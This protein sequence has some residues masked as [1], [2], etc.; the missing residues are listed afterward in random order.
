MADYQQKPIDHEDNL[1]KWYKSQGQNP[2]FYTKM[3]EDHINSDEFKTCL[4][5]ACKNDFPRAET[6]DEQQAQNAF[7]FDNQT[8]SLSE[9]NGTVTVW[10]GPS[11]KAP[12]NKDILPAKWGQKSFGGGGGK[13]PYKA[14]VQNA[15][16]DFEYVT[17]EDAQERTKAGSEFVLAIG[18]KRYNEEE[19]QEE[20]LIYKP[21][22]I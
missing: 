19:E 3:R 11:T 22:K 7:V 14:I 15:A 12:A 13:G 8:Y 16:Q 9:F 6:Q 1:A 10:Q 20:V 21:V 5:K 2:R 17:L 4:V 18:E